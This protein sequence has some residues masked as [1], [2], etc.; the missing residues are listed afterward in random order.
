MATVTG[1]A[2]R[3]VPIGAEEDVGALRRAVARAA[4]G[5]PG[6]RAGEAEL[7][8]TELGTN[9]LRH[10]HPG[11]YVLFRP[12]GEGIELLSVDHGPGIPPESVPPSPYARRAPAPPER[13]SH[14]SGGL[15]AGLPAV[16]RLARDFDCY[17]TR[18]GTVVLARLDRTERPDASRWRHGGVNIPYGNE[19]ESGDGWAVRT[20]GS[21][22]EAVVV[23]G[24]GHGAPAAVAARAALVEFRRQLMT[25]PGPFLRRA[26]EAMR[27]TRGGVLGACRIDADR[28]ELAFAGVGN[29]TGRVLHGGRRWPLL[30]RPGTLGTRVSPPRD[31]VERVPWAPGAV[32][33]L[34]SDGIRSG[35]DTAVYRGLLHRDPAVVA[36]VLH[37][38]HGRPADDATVLVVAEVP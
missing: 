10:A 34:T 9:L 25:G 31:H 26:H 18:A 21:T 17:A 22:L 19:E 11:G 7:A 37:R 30:G 14:A 4:A 38:D 20:G 23:D 35:W 29:I 33:V 1:T 28:G 2:H 32:L 12:V 13:L 24:L 3:R 27:A 5:R 36:A 6:L 15:G 16:R 8:A